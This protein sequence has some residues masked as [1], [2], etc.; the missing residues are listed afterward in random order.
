MR[1]RWSVPGSRWTVIACA[2]V[3]VALPALAQRRGG[4][5]GEYYDGG[6]KPNR[7]Y[8]G[9]FTFVRV[10]YNRE[11]YEGAM[12]PSQGIPWSHDY[13]TGETHFMKILN[14]LTTLNPWTDAGNILYLDDPQLMK[15][16]V[17][18]MVEPGFWSPSAKEAEGMRTYLLKGGY[19]IIDDFGPEHWF[20][21]ERQMRRVLPDVRFLPLDASSPVFDSFFRIP[22]PIGIFAGRPGAYRGTPQYFGVYEDND[23]SKRLMMVINYVNDLSEYWE[24]SDEGGFAPIEQSNEAYKVGV[25][26][27]IYGMTH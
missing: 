20:N 25:N 16:P 10:A 17:A 3:L 22:D 8:D 12:G 2:V 4:Q 13:P 23:P 11:M 14:E 27:V 21:F 18:Y 24:F 1:K 15:Y 5:R 26:Q 9:Q 6:W 7:P 19:M